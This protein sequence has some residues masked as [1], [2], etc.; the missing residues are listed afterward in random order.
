MSNISK[1]IQEVITPS[2]DGQLSG[3]RTGRF[4]AS[5]FGD[6]LS[7]PRTLT[8]A[9]ILDH[10]HL[11]PGTP[12]TDR[13]FNALLRKKIDEAG[14]VLFGDTALGLIASKAAERVTDRPAPHIATRSMDRGMILEHAARILLSRYW[15]PI[16]TTTFHPYGE[17]SGGTPDGFVDKGESTW[18]VKCPED[19]GDLLLFDAQV[20]DGDFEAMER[21]NRKHA[22]QLMVE[23]VSAGTK[24]ATI[25]M[26]TDR[27]ALHDIEE[28]VKGE[29]QTVMDVVSHKMG[30][31]E[32]RAI[33]YMYEGT[34]F[35]HISKRFELTDER[36]AR[37]DRTLASAEV[38]CLKMTAGRIS[39]PATP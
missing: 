7:E 24:Y 27:M 17:N 8:P 23:A 29:V 25:T 35:A 1:L 16:D 6:L 37:I 20:P 9:H 11:L 2:I 30:E 10:G 36:K 31:F 39:Q 28:H 26:F 15:K 32:N 18:Q 22:W 14:I 12:T 21:W 38:E 19:P 13:G 4:T 5:V 33:W 34:G 3:I